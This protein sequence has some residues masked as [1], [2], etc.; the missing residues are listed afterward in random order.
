MLPLIG[1][2]V[3]GGGSTERIHLVITP[4]PSPTNSPPPAPTVGPSK[5]AVQ[6]GDTLSGIARKFSVTVDAIVRANNIADPN[7]LS[8]GQVL[9]IPA[10]QVDVPP[11][12]TVASTGVP[13]SPL[14]PV[15]TGTITLG[16][17]ATETLPPAN[18]TPPQGPAITDPTQDAVSTPGIT[19][20]PTSRP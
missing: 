10:R 17:T 20:I 19:V 8:E 11:T 5:Y 4:V 3:G 6:P 12:V 13:G 1:C 14:T 7:S 9:T 2:D 16:P 18:A 15:I